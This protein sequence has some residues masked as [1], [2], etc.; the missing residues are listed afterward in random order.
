MSRSVRRNRRSAVGISRGP[1]APEEERPRAERIRVERED[2]RFGRAKSRHAFRTDDDF[3]IVGLER[4]SRRNGNLRR[5]RPGR[6]RRASLRDRLAGAVHQGRLELPSSSPIV[7]V[8]RAPRQLG[9]G[10]HDRP[11]ARASTPR[12]PARAAAAR[13]RSWRATTA[14]GHHLASDVSG[15]ATEVIGLTASP[16][17]AAR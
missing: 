10:S 7:S 15:G 6:E 12:T 8:R 1:D 9:N 4:R 5:E 16:A 2:G 14:P 17:F 13:V 3:V 11:R